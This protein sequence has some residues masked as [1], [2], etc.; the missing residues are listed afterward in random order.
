MKRVSVDLADGLYDRLERLAQKGGQTLTEMVSKY[1]LR[2]FPGEY[3]DS[4]WEDW[5]IKRAQAAAPPPPAPPP[6]LF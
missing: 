6:T 3:L 1:L 4:F 2:E 5:K